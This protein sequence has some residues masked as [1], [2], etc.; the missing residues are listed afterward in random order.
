ML[1]P[2]N[3]TT[4]VFSARFYRVPLVPLESSFRRESGMKSAMTVVAQC[5]QIVLCILA[6]VTAEFLM[7]DLKVCHRAAAL[8]TPSVPPQYSLA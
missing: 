6:R 4:F 7:M 8:T 5:N 1:S 3:A 2:Q